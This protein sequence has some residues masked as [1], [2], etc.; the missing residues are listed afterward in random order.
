MGS[1]VSVRSKVWKDYMERMV[2]EGSGCQGGPS[3]LYR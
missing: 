3:S 1:C 2:N